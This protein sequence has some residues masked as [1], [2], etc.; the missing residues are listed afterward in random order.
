M[1]RQFRFAEMNRRDKALMTKL[2]WTT[3]KTAKR[4]HDDAGGTT[5]PADAAPPQPPSVSSCRDAWQGARPL[6]GTNLLCGVAASASTGM[7]ILAWVADLWCYLQD[8]VGPSVF[9]TATRF[10]SD[11]HPPQFTFPAPYAVRV[12]AQAGVRIIKPRASAARRRRMQA[13]ARRRCV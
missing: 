9:H 1:D 4:K 7:P 11:L 3:P 13:P 10:I 6:L 12:E 5:I 2:H 8:F